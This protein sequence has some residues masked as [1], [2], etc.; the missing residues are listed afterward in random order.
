MNQGAAYP[1]IDAGSLS[2]AD[3][4]L[5]RLLDVVR[6]LKQVPL[7]RDLAAY[8]LR[9]Q[10]EIAEWHAITK[11]ETLFAQGDDGDALYIICHGGIDVRLGD[12]TLASLGDGECIG[13]LA[14]LDGESRSASAVATQDTT[15]LRVAADRFKN[16]LVTQPA[17]S[18]AMLRTLD[19]RIRE[20]QAGG[21]AGERQSS[22]P[23]MRRSQFMRA[24]K[25]GLQQL[26]A[27]MSF[28]RQVDLF[29]DLSTRAMAN[30]AGIAQEVVVYEGDTV[31]EQGDEGESLYLVCSGRLGV[32][33][34]ERLVAELER[35]ACVGEMSLI[36]G[37]PRSA[38]VEALEEGRLLRIG[39]EDFGSLLSNEPEIAL[40]LLKTLAQRLRTASR[41]Q[42]APP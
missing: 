31:F 18:R 19:R 13:D 9:E 30:L 28:L 27:T 3:R 5:Y 2:D 42:Q 20:T 40:A 6:F 10:A 21:R 24:Q 8:Y 35:N 33:V 7:F 12:T 36:S 22:L 23:P 39:S 38:T 25:L 15:L 29:R 1:T 34:G 41:A 16:M 14:L 37:K 17:M 32:R 4:E 11:D 26:V